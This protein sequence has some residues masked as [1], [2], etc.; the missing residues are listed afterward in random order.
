[1]KKQNGKW[2]MWMCMRDPIAKKLKL[3]SFL[4]NIFFVRFELVITISFI[5]NIFVF[6]WLKEFKKKVF[7]LPFLSHVEAFVQFDCIWIEASIAIIIDN[8]IFSIGIQMIY[9]FLNLFRLLPFSTL[10]CRPNICKWCVALANGNEERW[11]SNRYKYLYGFLVRKAW[12][13]FSF[14]RSVLFAVF[15]SC[16]LP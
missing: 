15:V 6:R 13:F 1:M 2:R 7:F 11:K 5:F 12:N 9:V 10:S 16:F 14:I 8:N 3:F 4:E